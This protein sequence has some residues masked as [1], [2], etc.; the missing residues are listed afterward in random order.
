MKR[1]GYTYSLKD[2]DIIFNEE[3]IL[4][5]DRPI[6]KNKKDLINRM[7]NE[8]RKLSKKV[9]IIVKESK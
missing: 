5:F 2:F 4:Y 3:G 8:W 9:Y 1:I 6:F 7:G